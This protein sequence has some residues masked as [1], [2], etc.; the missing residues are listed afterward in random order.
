M[1]I[2][3]L[4]DISKDG[5]ELSLLVGLDVGESQS[6]LLKDIDERYVSYSSKSDVDALSRL[7]LPVEMGE[8]KS[9]DPE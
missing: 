8:P 3:E 1:T 5:D 9:L 4:L 6:P 2:T 7:V